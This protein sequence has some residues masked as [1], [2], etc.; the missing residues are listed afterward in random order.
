MKD[1]YRLSHAQLAHTQRNYFVYSEYKWQILSTARLKRW[2]HIKRFIPFMHAIHRM[3][4][5]RDCVV[6]VVA[7]ISVQLTEFHS[8][9][10]FAPYLPSFVLA[11]S[12][13]AEKKCAIK[14]LFHYANWTNKKTHQQQR[15]MDKKTMPLTKAYKVLKLK[16]NVILLR[17][18][19][20]NNYNEQ[21]LLFFILILLWQKKS[22]IEPN[23]N[24]NGVQVVCACAH[25]YL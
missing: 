13:W 24:W 7:Q 16:C 10:Y 19:T 9:N 22:A 8:F 14:T 20:T 15:T 12:V 3:S 23:A 18:L 4:E 11:G 21:Q 6:V 1:V 17:N 2:L 5:D 25:T